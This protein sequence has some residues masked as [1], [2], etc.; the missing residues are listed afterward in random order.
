MS[1]TIISNV[2]SKVYE[3]SVA[4]LSNMTKGWQDFLEIISSLLSG[5]T[6][7][8]L[9]FGITLLAALPLGLIIAFGSMS[10]FK[11][12]N[13]VSRGFVWVIRGTPLMLQIIF[14]D[15]GPG[16]W[17]GMPIREPWQHLMMVCIAFSINYACYF[18][19]IY[20]GGIQSVPYGQY[21]AG[22]VLGMTKTQ[23]FFKVVLL[24]VVKRIIAPMSN[25]IITLVKDTALASTVISVD[26]FTVAKHIVNQKVVLWP[27]FGAGLFYLIFNGLLSFL[28]GKLE[29]KLDYFKV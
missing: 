1:A 20:R 10:K 27:I 2:F 17:L 24:Q 7:T 25:E 5:F 12:L 23:I 21:E 26:L 28:L 8:L 9:I 6:Y 16:L 13:L 22:Q 11:P 18:S 15:M 4:E 29:K 3:F 14:F 19:E